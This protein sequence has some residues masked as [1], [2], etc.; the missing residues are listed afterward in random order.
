MFI[1]ALF[2][3][4]LSTSKYVSQREENTVRIKDARPVD[5]LALA[6]G[7]PKG[8]C[9]KALRTCRGSIELAKLL[10]TGKIS[11]EQA[12]DAANPPKVLSQPP[13]SRTEYPVA[14]LRGTDNRERLKREYSARVAK[15]IGQKPSSESEKAY[16]ALCRCANPIGAEDADTGQV[17][18]LTRKPYYDTFT[19]WE[20]RN[21]CAAIMAV[22]QGAN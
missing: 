7:E 20:Y 15:F 17:R 14:A 11:T 12:K 2:P 9:E 10:L 1:S 6:T 18:I 19:E 22:V 4:S 8:K 5:R 3:A 13:A 21:H 16:E